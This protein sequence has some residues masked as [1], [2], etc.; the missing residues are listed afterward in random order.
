MDVQREEA[1]EAIVECPKG[2]VGAAFSR[3]DLEEPYA[4]VYSQAER[5]VALAVVVRAQLCEGDAL[6]G[7]DVFEYAGGMN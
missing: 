4:D 7:A 3:L 5:A 6:A 2:W 1:Q